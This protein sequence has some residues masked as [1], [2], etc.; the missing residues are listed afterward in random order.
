M[1]G[2]GYKIHEKHIAKTVQFLQGAADCV[3]LAVTTV[4]TQTAVISNSPFFA[5]TNIISLAN[6][7][8]KIEFLGTF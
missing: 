3:Y 6:F 5:R 7:V 2:S 1:I 8:T 4:L